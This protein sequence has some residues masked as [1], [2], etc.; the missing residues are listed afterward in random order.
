[1]ILWNRSTGWV[2]GD[3]YKILAINTGSTSTK[4]AAFEN[5]KK[6]F[7]ENIDH[8]AEELSG[9]ATIQEQQPFR[10][11]VVA[12]TL[13]KAGYSIE[14]FDVFVGRGGSLNPCEG[15]T[16]EVGGLLLE[17]ARGCASGPHPASVG[18]VIAYEFAQQ[19]AGKA[20]TVDPP[21][22]D[23]FEPIARISGIKS[24]PRESRAHALNQ[25]EAARRAAKDIGKP[26]EE[27]RLVV[28]HIGGGIS[29]GVHKCGRLVDATNLLNGDGP[30][31]PTRCGTLPVGKV[32]KMMEDG[33]GAERIRQYVLKDGGMVDHLGTSDMREVERMIEGGDEYA[34]LVRDAQI[35]SIAKTIGAFATVLEGRMDAIVLTGGLAHSAAIVDGIKSRVGFIA[36]VLSYPGE[37]EMEALANGALRVVRGMESLKEY[38][39]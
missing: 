28:A 31:A 25:K 13:A 24:I 9:F 19:A 38:K 37:F 11:D 26:Y 22:V 3:N 27:L 10:R 35:Y 1:M 30:M 39:G 7:Q 16:Y 34:R 15:G 6:V 2:M 20:Y 23:E 18:T 33:I 29:V 21:D 17:H 5:D 32:V 36:P 14:N 12:D 8:S 4:I